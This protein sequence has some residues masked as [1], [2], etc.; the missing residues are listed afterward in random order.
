MDA[1][2]IMFESGYTLNQSDFF[3]LI[4]VLE[5]QQ[6]VSSVYQLEKVTAFLMSAARLFGF[7]EIQTSKRLTE[8]WFDEGRF[9]LASRSLDLS[10]SVNFNSITATGE[11]F[12]V[13]NTDSLLI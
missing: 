5:V 11:E 3:E 8:D 10:Q 13:E 6:S 12:L 4:D 1:L 7:D 2:K 9:E